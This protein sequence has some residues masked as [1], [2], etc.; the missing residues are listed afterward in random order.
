MT[1]FLILCK[2]IRTS[3]KPTDFAHDTLVSIMD[4]RW[5]YVENQCSLPV[6]CASA[7]LER[8][9]VSQ[10][11][12]YWH[13]EHCTH[14]GCT[15]IVDAP[16]KEDQ[17]LVDLEARERSAVRD[18]I[19]RQLSNEPEISIDCIL[20]GKLPPST[21]RD[22]DFQSE[23]LETSEDLEVDH[24][25]VK[26]EIQLLK[27]SFEEAKATQ[28]YGDL[29]ICTFPKR[30][31]VVTF[32]EEGESCIQAKACKVGRP[33]RVSVSTVEEGC[34]CKRQPQ[35]RGSSYGYRKR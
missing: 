18:S 25:E 20:E 27:E 34:V 17:L 16:R 30:Q 35:R 1:Y 33:I 10:K 3:I 9:G 23:F 26:T 19:Q 5:F 6:P 22:E 4:C 7:K 13:C 31:K 24:E 8:Q 21:T 28:T 32:N 11:P 29:F 14:I 2:Q 15:S 12:C